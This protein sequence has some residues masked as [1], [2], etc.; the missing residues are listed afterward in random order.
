MPLS[1]K[2][3]DT[4]LYLVEH[5]GE[6]VSKADLLR[7]VWPGV[8]V[9]ENSLSQCVSVLRRALGEDPRAHKFIVTVPGRGYRFIAEL[10]RS[11]PPGPPASDSG[12][13]EPAALAVLPFKPLHPSAS[14]EALELGM[15]D[16][17]IARIGAL[18]D[19]CVAPLSS[20]RRYSGPDHDA[21]SAGRALGVS[22]VLEGSLQQHAGR[23]RVSARLLDVN[24]GRQLWAG[25]FD[26][27]LADIFAIQDAIAERV[28]DAVLATVSGGDRQ[29]LRHRPTHD[30]QAYQLYV[31]G[32]SALTRPSGANLERALKYLDEAT[33]RDP[34]FALAYVCMA[35]CWALLGVFGMKAPHEVFPHARAA[36]LKALA[37]DPELAEAHAELAHILWVYDLDGLRA[38]RA[39]RRALDIDP[40]S[41]MAH[42]YFGLALATKG[43]LE[44]ALAAL[45]R[46][47]A[48]EPLAVN[49][50]ANIG[51]VHYYARR[52]DDAIAQA[53]AAL[54]LD[55]RF[56]HAYS[57]LGRSLLQIGEHDLAIE[58]FRA[59]KGVTIG[60]DADVPVAYALGGNRAAAHRELDRL[61]G[62]RSRR[63]VSSC[64]IAMIH[65]ALGETDEALDW[66][67]R[68]FEERAQPIGFLLVEPLF[69]ALHA[70]PRF[71]ALLRKLGHE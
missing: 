7:T 21:L 47:Q 13:R 10:E 46:A 26:E 30:A 40:R 49:I 69:D 62:E 4:L 1:T 19:V 29:R 42:H 63:Y 61:L 37:I 33:R 43:D 54:D 24:G 41:A 34:E 32:W 11:R 65:A 52:Y 36:V 23:L 14:N 60:D 53:R 68:A 16:A 12:P 66:L 59:R 15:A 22:R 67:E 31:N 3:F 28:A 27:P 39:L 48:A 2:A 55:R 6:V 51:M 5:S 70:E 20:V 57:V 38:E 56:D 45:R 44:S 18:H 71:R 58:Q 17:L 64:S 9:E 8:V 25:R 35:D 50:N